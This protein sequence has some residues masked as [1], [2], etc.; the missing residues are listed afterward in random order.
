MAPREIAPLEGYRLWARDYDRIL[1]GHCEN[2]ILERCTLRWQGSTIL[3]LGCGTGRTA[4]W[5]RA[6]A[7][8]AVLD[9][10]DFCTEMLD[11]ARAKGLYRSLTL[12]DICQG[13]QPQQAAYD[14]VVSVLVANHLDELGTLHRVANAALRPEGSL[15]LVEY[16]PFMVL[17]RREIELRTP[18]GEAVIIR[19]R[20]HMI[21]DYIAAGLAAGF[22]LGGC[23]ESFVTEAWVAH[24][25]S[26]ERFLGMPIGV[27]M[28]W[29]KS[30]PPAVPQ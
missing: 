26:L 7:P 10:V 11:Q 23:W 30:P 13:W 2:P 20:R 21:S 29:R 17:S 9:G 16:H 15:L 5:I 18:A 1:S 19:N 14:H 8:D 4:A 27:G 25:P 3:D 12:A 28:Q 24:T 6:A 22:S